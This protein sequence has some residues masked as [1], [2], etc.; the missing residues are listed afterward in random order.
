[1]Q[2]AFSLIENALNATAAHVAILDAAGTIQYA[3]QAWTSFCL[4]NGGSEKSCGVGANYLATCEQVCGEQK[5][6]ANTVSHGIRTVLQ[7]DSPE[8]RLDYACHS[9][10]E[11]RWFQLLGYADMAL[12]L[13]RRQGRNQIAFFRPELAERSH[14]LLS[15]EGRL[16]RATDRGEFSMVYQPQYHAKSGAIIGM[17]ALLRWHDADL[18][19][20]PPDE[21]IPLAE[22]RGLIVPIGEWVFEQVCRQIK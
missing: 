18:G 22:E 15:M 8:F 17:E 19:Q 10:F 9:P 1:M 11:Q 20:V 7:G 13:A 4:L 12:R 6:E 16:R 2:P 21:F 3:N 14:A 5:M